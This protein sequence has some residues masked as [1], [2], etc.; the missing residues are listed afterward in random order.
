L[1]A[2]VERY[3]HA[4]GIRQKAVQQRRLPMRYEPRDDIIEVRS[5]WR[6]CNT[7][8]EGATS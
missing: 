4:V 2:P 6:E 8:A 5:L 1:P 3:D 7:D